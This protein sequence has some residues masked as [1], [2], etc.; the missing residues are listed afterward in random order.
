M[1]NT[2]R[3]RMV[4]GLVASALLAGGTPALAATYNWCPTA[5]SGAIICNNCTVNLTCDISGF[6]LTIKGRYVTLD[7][8]WHT[9][10]GYNPSTDVPAVNDQGTG[11]T[12]RNLN[13]YFPLDGIRVFQD[14]YAPGAK[15]IQNV[16]AYGSNGSGVTLKGIWEPQAKPYPQTGYVRDSWA[17]AC[18][19]GFTQLGGDYRLGA[20]GSVLGVFERVTGSSNSAWGLYANGAKAEIAESQFSGNGDL[21]VLF[22]NSYHGRIHGN[23]TDNNNRYGYLLFNNTDT[24]ITQNYGHG[25]IHKDCYS[26]IGGAQWGVWNDFGSAVGPGCTN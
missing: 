18:H 5:S 14:G 17:Y 7:G 19:Y 25:N 20:A 9:I 24:W 22:S 3:S 8:Q 16:F 4:A 26:E 11:T 2:K 15:T 10:S 13:I 1:I 12:I 23:T 21:G 6:G